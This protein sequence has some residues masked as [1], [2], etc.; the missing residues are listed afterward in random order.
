MMA[1][2]QPSRLQHFPVSWFAMVMGLSG[3]TIALHRAETVF[4]LAIQ[5]S[6]AALVFTITVFLALAGLYL[7]KA[8][9]YP[10][11]VHRADSDQYCPA[12]SQ[13]NPFTGC[14]DTGRCLAP[15]F[16]PVRAGH[17]D[18]PHALRDQSHEPGLVHSHC[19]QHSGAHRR[20]SAWFYRVV[21]VLLQH[22][23]GV[24]AGASGYHL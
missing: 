20:C 23:P 24:L 18:S 6:L 13:Q 5:P 19:G 21:L 4:N 11:H 16:H 9:R 15:G 10:Q 2:S 12:A 7:L 3:L 1:E 17:L 22:W 8:V 14:L